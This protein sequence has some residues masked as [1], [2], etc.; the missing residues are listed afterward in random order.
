[1][2][3]LKHSSG[4]NK[5]ILSFWQ[6]NAAF[7][8]HPEPISELFDSLKK[9]ITETWYG[10]QIHHA[11]CKNVKCLSGYRTAPR[12]TQKAGGLSDA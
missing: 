12:L 7:V 9:S 1:M 6:F 4:L 11:V 3:A 10:G 5:A 8:W 2:T